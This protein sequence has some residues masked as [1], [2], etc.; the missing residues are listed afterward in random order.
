MSSQEALV[1]LGDHE[2]ETVDQ[3]SNQDVLPQTDTNETG[4]GRQVTI[5]RRYWENVSNWTVRNRAAMVPVLGVLSAVGVITLTASDIMRHNQSNTLEAQLVSV[6]ST[7]MSIASALKS[8]I[9]NLEAEEDNLV[10]NVHSLQAIAV[11]DGAVQSEL[12]EASGSLS[13]MRA[14]DAVLA[15]QSTVQEQNITR[16]IREIESFSKAYQAVFLGSQN[17]AESKAS[18][19]QELDS[20]LPGSQSESALEKDLREMRTMGE[21][22]DALPVHSSTTQ[23][24]SPTVTHG[25]ARPAMWP[26]AFSASATAA[27]DP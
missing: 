25:A 6:N 11:S 7:C 22:L 2:D 19:A 16:I 12:S 20:A 21:R 15:D 23:G 4:R 24:G 13:A 8:E 26:K 14:T 17:E 3:Q 9:S 5:L 1:Q 10:E 27:H 18:L